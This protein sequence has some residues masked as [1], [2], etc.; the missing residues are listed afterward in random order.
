MSTQIRTHVVEQVRLI[1]VDLAHAALSLLLTA[2]R[3]VQRFVT[4]QA[5]MHAI[6]GSNRQ[7]TWC[8]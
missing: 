1:S 5:S 3:D 8:P 7:P 2:V 6:G 4:S